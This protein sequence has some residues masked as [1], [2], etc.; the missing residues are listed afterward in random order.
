VLVEEGPD[1]GTGDVQG[2]GARQGG[3]DVDAEL[4]G[5]Q[6]EVGKGGVYR[7]CHHDPPLPPGHELP[8]T[9]PGGHRAFAARSVVR[10]LAQEEKRL[11]QAVIRNRVGS[12]PVSSP[13]TN[14]TSAGRPAT[15]F[16]QNSSP[17]RGARRARQVVTRP[18]G[19]VVA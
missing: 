16:C 11:G 19:K 15:T 6:S 13:S 7:A 8:V 17:L 4:T 5:Q 18:S 9:L 12:V 10:L 14:E 3:V 1:V 2:A